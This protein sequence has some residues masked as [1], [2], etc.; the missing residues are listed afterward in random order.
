MYTCS[1]NEAVQKDVLETFVYNSLHGIVR[2]VRISHETE[3]YCNQRIS[4]IMKIV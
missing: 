3:K 1:F 2:Q 4:S